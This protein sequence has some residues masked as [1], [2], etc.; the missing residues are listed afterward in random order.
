MVRSKKAIWLLYKLPAPAMSYSAVA[1]EACRERGKPL[2]VPGFV[3]WSDNKTAEW[4][5]MGSLPGTLKASQ[6][7]A[8]RFIL[9][10]L[11]RNL[12]RVYLAGPPAQSGGGPQIHRP[13]GPSSTGRKYL[14]R[15]AAWAYRLPSDPG[16]FH[17]SE[18]ETGFIWLRPSLREAC[19]PL[20]RQERLSLSQGLPAGPGGQTVA[21]AHEQGVVHQA[22][23][24]STFSWK[25]TGSGGQFA[26]G[27]EP[28]GLS[29]IKS[30]CGP[31][32]QGE[33]ATPQANIFSLGVWVPAY[34][35]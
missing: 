35:R 19:W 9:R 22:L 10:Q 5:L 26:R 13:G 24:P 15:E 7:I 23:N 33:E 21:F 2:F 11:R 28:G 34:R 29:G 14:I 27:R 32:V 17:G 16:R 4:G 18:G 6:I 1:S 3:L 30:L 31:E 25:Q 8:R 20:N 12:G